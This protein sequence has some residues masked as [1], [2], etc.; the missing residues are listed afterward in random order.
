[1]TTEEF[2]RRFIGLPNPEEAFEWLKGATPEQIRTLGED[3]TTV[4]SIQLVEELYAAGAVQVLAVE[5]D[6]YD[7]GENTG[8]GQ[9]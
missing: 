2:A 3:E 7:D 9:A 8:R 4:A 1:M 5:I 6:R